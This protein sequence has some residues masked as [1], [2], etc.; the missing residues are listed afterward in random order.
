MPKFENEL[1]VFLLP[2]LSIR[3]SSFP[4]DGPKY[5]YLRIAHAGFL[6]ILFKVPSL[7]LLRKE[8]MNAF[9]V[10]PYILVELPSKRQ[11]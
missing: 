11:K 1:F 6:T 2:S 10:E 8:K 7:S 4:N 9:R 3:M 5:L